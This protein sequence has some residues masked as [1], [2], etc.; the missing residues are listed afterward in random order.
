[1]ATHSSV[2]AWRIPGMGEPDGLLSMG[3]Q[4]RTRLK[5]LSSSSLSIFSFHPFADCS[6][7]YIWVVDVVI[8]F[9]DVLLFFYFFLLYDSFCSLG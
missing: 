1:M 2:L 9:S 4:R 3:S 8:G 6:Y 7:T 5:R